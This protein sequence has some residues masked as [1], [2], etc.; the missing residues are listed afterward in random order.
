MD[1]MDDTSTWFREWLGVV[2]QQAFTLANVDPNQ[3]CHM[4]S[5][6]HN[7]LW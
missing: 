2:R 6:G 1:L 4:M 7:E 3:C 5:L